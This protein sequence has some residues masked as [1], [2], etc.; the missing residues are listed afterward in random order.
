MKRVMWL[1][2]AAATIGFGGCG[3]NDQTSAGPHGGGTDKTMVMPKRG[4]P[5][6]QQGSSATHPAETALPEQAVP[7]GAKQAVSDFVQALSKGDTDA[8]RKI[9]MPREVFAKTLQTDNLEAYYDAQQQ[10]FNAS[11]DKLGGGLKGVTIVDTEL[12]FDG[13]AGTLPPGAHVG[14]ARTTKDTVIAEDVAVIVKQADDPSKE[15]AVQFDRLIQT[16]QGWFAI[17]PIKVGPRLRRQP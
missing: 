16:D 2:A 17:D 4:E 9:F 5:A 3:D 1:M 12:K 11:L 6:V 8:A 7:Q 13:H 10:A 14:N 15:L